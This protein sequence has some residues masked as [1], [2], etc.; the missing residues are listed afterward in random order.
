VLSDIE[1]KLAEPEPKASGK[2]SCVFYDSEVCVYLGTL[3]TGMLSIGTTVAIYDPCQESCPSG[4]AGPLVQLGYATLL[5]ISKDSEFLKSRSKRI[6]PTKGPS[7]DGAGDVH[8]P[9]V[10]HRVWASLVEVLADV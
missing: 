7:R 3:V 5:M 4:L 1:R 2:S 9:D 6:P 8:R 10:L